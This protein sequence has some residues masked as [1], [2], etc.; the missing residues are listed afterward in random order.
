LPYTVFF[1]GVAADPLA[2]Q[3][4]A[5][6]VKNRAAYE[7]RATGAPKARASTDKRF[8]AQAKDL[9]ARTYLTQGWKYQR[10][11]LRNRVSKAFRNELMRIHLPKHVWV[12]EFGFPDELD[13][14][15]P[16]NRR[17]RAHVVIDATGSDFWES[18]IFTHAPG[19]LMTNAFDP[20]MPDAKPELLMY[21][22]PDDEPYLP[23]VRG[24]PCYGLCEEAA[25]G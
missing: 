4:I 14:A 13:D 5:D 8:Y 15:N 11:M 19:L 16:C 10:R 25:A 17:I 21:A 3:R 6:V 24:W 12:T 22:S 2:R 9:M 7:R 23:K 1:C 20:Y 18:T